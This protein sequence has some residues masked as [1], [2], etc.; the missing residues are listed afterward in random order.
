MMTLLRQVRG[1]KSFELLGIELVVAVHLEDPRLCRRRKPAPERGAIT[2]ILRVRHDTRTGAPCDVRSRVDRSV[3]DHDDFDLF[4]VTR[5]GRAEHA[6]TVSSTFAS[7]FKAGST[8]EIPSRRSI[9]PSTIPAEPK[10]PHDRYAAAF[11]CAVAAILEDQ[12]RLPLFVRDGSARQKWSVERERADGGHR[13]QDH[14]DRPRILRTEAL[15]RVG[16]RE[17][18][19][20]E[21]RAG[22]SR[23]RLRHG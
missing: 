6:V 12:R 11:R 19:G 13:Q 23:G 9:T 5:C 16:E 20:T 14:G 1:N 2:A 22:R 7:S 3:V 18:A 4:A 17:V 10:R 15:D 21:A 8:T